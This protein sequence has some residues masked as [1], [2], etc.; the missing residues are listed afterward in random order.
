MRCIRTVLCAVITVAALHTPLMAGIQQIPVVRLSVSAEIAADPGQV[1]DYMT[2]GKNL[3][4]WCPY[5]KTPENA[6]IKLSSVGDVLEFKDDWGNGGRSIVT[7]INAPV[8]L[9]ISHDPNDGSYMCQSRLTLSATGKGT[10]IRYIEQYT[11]ESTPE[12]LKAT[13]ASME[14]AMRETLETLRKGVEA[15]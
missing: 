10:E 2:T 8:E 9:R 12:D 6:A 13:A 4:N 15:Q 14:T 5:W 7:F 1:W 11:D 3:V